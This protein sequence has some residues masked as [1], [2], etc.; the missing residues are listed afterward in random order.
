MSPKEIMRLE[1][2][3][4]ERY[5]D[6]MEIWTDVNAL[7]REVVRLRDGI[8]TVHDRTTNWR[9]RDDLNAL[10]DGEPFGA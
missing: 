9:V 4:K 8:S 10:L 5:D 6:P 2:L 3:Y 1:R 7:L